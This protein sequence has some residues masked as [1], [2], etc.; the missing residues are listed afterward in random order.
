MIRWLF[1][2]LI[3]F[4]ATAQP[5]R[6]ISLAPHTTELVYTLGAGDHLIAVSD[7]SDYPEAAKGLPRVASYQGVNFEAITALQPDLII[8]WQGGNKPQDLARLQQLGFTLYLSVPD[9]PEAIATDLRQLGAL[10]QAPDAEQLA[11]ALEARLA[12]L[13]RDYA[14]KPRIKVFYYLSSQPLITASNNAWPVQLLDI[15]NADSIFADSLNDY[16]SVT[17]ETIIQRQPQKIIAAD[18]ATQSHTQQFWQRWQTLIPQSAHS[19]VAADANKLHRFT[20]R[21][22][23]GLQALCSDLRKN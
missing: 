12:E 14:S 20:P 22:L 7:Y 17:V 11:L 16:P 23:D 21:L 9:T 15:C 10:L 2:L 8:G 1:V 4:S 13:R 19:I 6:I 18:G 5:T 3:A